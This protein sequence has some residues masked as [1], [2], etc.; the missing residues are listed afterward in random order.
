MKT[1]KK[2]IHVLQHMQS[3]KRKRGRMLHDVMCKTIDE[4]A[5][6]Y[7]KDLAIQCLRRLRI[8][9]VS[10]NSEQIFRR[11]RLNNWIAICQRLRRL[12][13]H[14][15][16]YYTYRVKYHVWNT[17]LWMLRRRYQYGT[18]GLDKIIER[19]KQLLLKYSTVCLDDGTYGSLN[20]GGQNGG[21]HSGHSGHSR[22]A[23]LLAMNS[24]LR[25]TFYR[26]VEL[27]A[28]MKT[29]AA[30]VVLLDERK[31]IRTMRKVFTN[32]LLSVKCTYTLG[33]RRARMKFQQLRVTADLDM[34]KRRMLVPTGRRSSRWTRRKHAYVRAK[35]KQNAR[36]GDS[37]KKLTREWT[38]QVE[39]RTKLEQRLLFLEFQKRGQNPTENLCLVPGKGLGGD[40]GVFTQGGAQSGA[41][42]NSSIEASL[43]EQSLAESSLDSSSGGV[44]SGSVG[45]GGSVGSVGSD[46]HHVSSFSCLPLSDT[47]VLE[48][49]TVYVDGWIVGLATT[50]SW[51][52]IAPAGMKSSPRTNNNNNNSVT[53]NYVTERKT[54]L[55]GKASGKGQTFT[56]GGGTH[57]ATRET[58][59]A[60][61][62]FVGDVVGRLRFVTNRGRRSK[63][64]GV[65]PC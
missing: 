56:L 28:E 25:A 50:V 14:M 62:G 22:E 5:I 60:V 29:K 13:R 24:D 16:Y 19:R 17:W 52:T 54:T 12:D 10:A 41:P 59:V 6:R 49:I 20:G 39:L 36:Q 9:A 27:T 35:L 4:Q 34:W 31:R 46:H 11:A 44:G 18:K 47:S 63:W 32:L 1:Q 8:H 51:K 26:W 65:G 61:E 43:G 40:V 64:Y 2:R 38:K 3:V 48:S 15:H 57:G 30:M 58:L 37:F 23:Q 33:R 42:R 45:S 21:G 7:T 53:L 55:H